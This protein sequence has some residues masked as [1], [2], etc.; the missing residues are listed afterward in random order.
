MGSKLAAGTK[1][2]LEDVEAVVPPLTGSPVFRMCAQ[3][4]EVDP[5]P[6]ST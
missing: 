3:Q 2:C 1:V 5:V 6:S 4:R